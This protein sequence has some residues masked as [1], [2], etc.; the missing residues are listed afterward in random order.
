MNQQ[1]QK[2][3]SGNSYNDFVLEELEEYRTG[4]QKRRHRGSFGMLCV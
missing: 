1:Y 4:L 2:K 3:K